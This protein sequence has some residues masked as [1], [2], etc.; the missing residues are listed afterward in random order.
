MLLPALTHA[1][2]RFG[3][4]DTC[5]V[6][7]GGLTERRAAAAPRKSPSEGNLSDS[8]VGLADK[9][10]RTEMQSSDTSRCDA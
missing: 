1:K 6:R 9:S 7:A 3:W 8:I 2:G 10:P 4:V 5:K